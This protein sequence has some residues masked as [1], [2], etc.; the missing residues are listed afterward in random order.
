MWLE[1][2]PVAFNAREGWLFVR[3]V[4]LAQRKLRDRSKGDG[5]NN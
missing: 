4:D 2:P 5:K 3:F 1:G